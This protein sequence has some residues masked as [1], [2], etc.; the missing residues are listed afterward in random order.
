V[1]VGDG[2][3]LGDG[4]GLGLA[5]GLGD[6]VG[7]GVGAGVGVGVGVSPEIMMRTPCVLEPLEART[8]TSSVQLCFVLVTLFR[9]P[10]ISVWRGPKLIDEVDVSFI[11]MLFSPSDDV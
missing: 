6:G 10:V 5:E 3:G 7:V 4:D 1:G 11:T 9:P 8:T 2:L